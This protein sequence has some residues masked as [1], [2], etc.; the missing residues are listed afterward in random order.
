MIWYRYFGIYQISLKRNTINYEWTSKWLIR[1]Y[2][3]IDLFVAIFLSFF[4]PF[5]I[6][7]LQINLYLGILFWHEL[8]RKWAKKRIYLVSSGNMN[9]QIENQMVVG[10][11]LNCTEGTIST[12]RDRKIYRRLI[13]NL[14]QIQCQKEMLLV[15]LFILFFYLFAFAI[16]TLIG[17]ANIRLSHRKSI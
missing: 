6:S 5:F 2:R 8:M 11:K 17:P 12:K 10:N 16:F 7:R 14:F 1:L 9:T 3:S 4:V 15:S 13:D